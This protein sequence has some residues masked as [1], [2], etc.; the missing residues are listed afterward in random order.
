MA[1][2]NRILVIDDESSIRE[3]LE[4]F[5]RE[6]GLNVQTAGDAR[7]GLGKWRRLGP[8]VIILDIRLP[9]RS[10][11]DVLAEITAKDREVKVIMITAHHD[12]ETTIAA[13]R[14][15]AYDYIHKPL[16]VEEL[17]RALDKALYIARTT[18]STAPLV[19]SGEPPPGRRLVGNTPAMREIFKSIGLLSKNQATV[20]IQGETGTGKELIA[21][22]IHDSSDFKD[23][24]FVTI[25]CT[26]LVENLLESELFGHEK[27]AFTGAAE[28]KPGRLELAGKGTIFFDEV[29]DLPPLLQSKLLRFLEYRQFTR[30]GGG[31]PIRS[32]ARIIAAT[33]RDL[34]AMVARGAF[35][36]DLLF[37]LKVISMM[38]PP[39]KDRI[40]DLPDLAKYWLARINF[41]M[42]LRVTRMESGVMQGLC[43]Y[44][45]PGNVR[46]LKNVLTKAALESRGQVLLTEAVKACLAA[47]PEPA[48]RERPRTLEEVEKEHIIK[49]LE[50]FG[51][52]QSAASRAL[53]ISRPTLRK[54]LKVYGLQA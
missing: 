9:D 19:G 34:E 46:E 49:A 48:G 5:L 43:A 3:S 14:R 51:W 18:L 41:E 32:Q 30:V 21:R 47:P 50:R 24:P 7:E 29:G 39:L 27:G 40:A 8:Q 22:I 44:P 42:N 36:P 52:N 25:D 28:A 20:L 26:T 16:D 4:M 53:G 37:R 13:M 23:Q 2:L 31:V 6:K 12:M 54:R 10:G 33:N 17:E 45:W 15:G 1:G 11:L 35:R 38:V